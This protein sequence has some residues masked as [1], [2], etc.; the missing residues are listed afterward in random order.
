MTE[1]F[2]Q[3]QERLQGA[4]NDV[5]KSPGGKKL[6]EC[7]LLIGGRL[8]V[9]VVMKTLN[10]VQLAVL[11]AWFQEKGDKIGGRK[12]AKVGHDG[13]AYVFVEQAEVPQ[14]KLEFGIRNFYGKTVLVRQETENSE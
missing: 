7:V 6:Q 13:K 5:P 14:K 11:N 2:V 9:P 4:F 1:D 3:L 10:A 12:S 8:V